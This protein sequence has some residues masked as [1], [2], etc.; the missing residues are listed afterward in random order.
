MALNKIAYLSPA[1]LME[2]VI[3]QSCILQMTSSGI[4]VEMLMWDAE[5]KK[6]EFAVMDQLCTR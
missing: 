6:Q 2:K 4:L 1:Y 5:K 3:I